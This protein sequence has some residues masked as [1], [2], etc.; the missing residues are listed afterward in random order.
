MEVVRALTWEQIGAFVRRS[1]TSGAAG[2]T[3]L[4][5]SGAPADLVVSEVDRAFAWARGTRVP[6]DADAPDASF[7]RPHGPDTVYQG[8]R[9]L[10]P[11]AAGSDSHQAAA[12]LC[13][14][15][16]SLRYA[17]RAGTYSMALVREMLGGGNAFSSGG[18]GK[19]MYSRFYQRILNANPS[20]E[21]TLAVHHSFLDS[22]LFG[23]YLAGPDAIFRDLVLAV[24]PVIGNL[25][26]TLQ[27][28]Q[29][30]PLRAPVTSLSVTD[31]TEEWHRSRN[32]MTTKL[33]TSLESRHVEMEDL[34]RQI[35][36]SGTYAAPS[37]VLDDILAL[38]PTTVADT[39]L[40]SLRS[41]VTLVGF[42]SESVLR[43][44]PSEEQVRLVIQS[45]IG[46]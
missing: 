6:V 30:A 12:M 31:P 16:P 33:L 9:K 25:Y 3:M 5:V 8:G 24:L 10:Y 11:T 20:V 32:L 19:G 40:E 4:G 46:G 7:A 13:F 39:L 14:R 37:E 23:V 21:S 27:G 22:G 1:F 26:P 35:L 43:A 17:P 38:E 15:A 41:P 36:C 18:P 45:S 29:T 28:V 44:L 2:S 34:M 42:G